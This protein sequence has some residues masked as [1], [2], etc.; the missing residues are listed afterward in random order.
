ML[1]RECGNFKDTYKGDMAI[2]PIPLDR[3][4]MVVILVLAFGVIPTVASDY[5]LSSIMIQFYCFSL[6]A[7]GLNFLT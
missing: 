2:F 5:W 7:L 6:A 1:Y 4:G 3:W